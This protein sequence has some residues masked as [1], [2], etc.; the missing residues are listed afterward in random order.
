MNFK[1]KAYYINKAKYYC[2]LILTAIVFDAIVLLGL[3]LA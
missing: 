3:M 1:D 2:G